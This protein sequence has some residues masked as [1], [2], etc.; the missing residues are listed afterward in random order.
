M[1]ISPKSA[2]FTLIELMVAIALTGILSAAVFSLFVSQ[3]RTFNSQ[4]QTVSMRQNL[5]V[6]LDF[7]ERDIRTAG[8]DPGNTGNFG[9]T[10]IRNRDLN[11]ALAPAGENAL[12]FTTDIDSSGTLNGNET[13]S[14]SIYDFDA[15]GINDLARNAGGGRQMVGEGVEALG[16][17]YAYADE[18][19]SRMLDAATGQPIWAFDSNNDNLLDRRLDTNGDGL[20][21]INDNPAG[22]VLPPL[23]K[24]GAIIVP[25]KQIRA[26]RIWILA[27]SRQADTGYTAANLQFK[28]GNRN[29]ILANDNVRRQLLTTIVKGRNL[30]L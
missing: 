24:T 15:D 12:W 19:G 17:A 20:I 21:D 28:V 18:D 5:R 1:R 26:V 3:N 29:I 4:E 9:I 8:Y 7:I 10:D 11:N 14:Y 27:R 30:G 6:S 13:I 22:V 23:S 16:L 2:G 25:L